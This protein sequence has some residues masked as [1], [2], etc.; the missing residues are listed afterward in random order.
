MN[1]QPAAKLFKEPA[2]WPLIPPWWLLSSTE[3]AALLNVKPA[4]LHSWRIRGYGPPPYPPMYLKPTQGNPLYYQ[5]GALRSWAAS[6][7]GLSY[8]FEDQCDSFLSEIAPVLIRGAGSLQVRMDLF[9]EIFEEKRQWVLEGGESGMIS[10]NHIQSLD[11]YYS[12]QPKPR[13]KRPPGSRKRSG[14]SRGSF[15]V[16]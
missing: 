4:T 3:S 11:V 14:S 12:R 7:L 1:E 16:L 2:S 13:G 8:S 15:R 5:Y 10:T 6:K 9:Q